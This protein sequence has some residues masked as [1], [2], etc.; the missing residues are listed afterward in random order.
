[1]PSRLYGKQVN[2]ESDVS[3]DA[4]VTLMVD[5][6]HIKVHHNRSIRSDQPICKEGQ[7]KDMH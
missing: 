3:S 1:M 4:H 7:R 5:H 2:T 6:W